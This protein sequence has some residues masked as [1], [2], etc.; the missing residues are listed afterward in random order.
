[1]YNW[2]GIFLVLVWFPRVRMVKT[3]NSLFIRIGNVN[4]FY[5]FICMCNLSFFLLTEWYTSTV[6][7]HISVSGFCKC[8]VDDL[9]FLLILSQC[10]LFHVFSYHKIYN[11]RLLIFY[12]YIYNTVNFILFYRNPMNPCLYVFF[13]LF[14]RH[15]TSKFYNDTFQFIF[16]L[17]LNMVLILNFLSDNNSR[18][19]SGL[20]LYWNKLRFS[21]RVVQKKVFLTVLLK[22][23]I[24]F[25]NLI[26][27]VKTFSCCFIFLNLIELKFWMGFRC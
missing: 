13:F 15:V 22:C 1:M 21:I 5:F 12:F 2:R 14:T 6:L 7:T 11:C 10:L 18:V 16:D 23:Y 19:K 8:F 24:L 17:V 4:P 25:L 3:S 26:G 9:G 20:T 27:F